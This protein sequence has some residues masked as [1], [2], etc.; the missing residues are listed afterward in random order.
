MIAKK[1]ED[2]RNLGKIVEAQQVHHH[3]NGW[4][5]LLCDIDG[6]KRCVK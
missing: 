1:A 3:L 5:P 4:K 2:Y 6:L